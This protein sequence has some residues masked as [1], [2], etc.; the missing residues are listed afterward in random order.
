MVKMLSRHVQN[1]PSS[2]LGKTVKLQFKITQNERDK[3]IV[4]LILLSLK[5]GT[6]RTDGSCQIATVTRFEDIINIG[7]PILPKIWDLIDFIKVAE[8]IKAKTHLTSEGLG[9]IFVYKSGMNKGRDHA[10]NSDE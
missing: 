4:N 1:V 3:E 8:L 7:F 6:L 9:Q 2:K 5:C 10:S